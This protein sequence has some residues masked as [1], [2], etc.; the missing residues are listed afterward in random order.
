[1]TLDLTA[2]EVDLIYLAL[3]RSAALDYKRLDPQ[4]FSSTAFEL[5]KRAADAEHL[6]ERLPR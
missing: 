2:E 1:M 5:R 6:R 4:D 3:T